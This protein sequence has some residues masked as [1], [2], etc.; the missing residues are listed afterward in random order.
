VRHC[1]EIAR[2]AGCT[3]LSLTTDARRVD[4]H[5]FYERL[6]FKHSHRGYR[7]TF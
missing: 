7:Y 4:A 1:L 3:R 5:R 6:D 2:D